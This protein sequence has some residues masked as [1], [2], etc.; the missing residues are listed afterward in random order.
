[1]EQLAGASPPAG[2][3][4]ERY[5]AVFSAVEINSSF[6]HPHR[7]MINKRW[8]ASAPDSFRF[9]VKVPKA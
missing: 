3:H 4:L 8:A 1:L 5:T 9:A 2:S 6:Y 7:S